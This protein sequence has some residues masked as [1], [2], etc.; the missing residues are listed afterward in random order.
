M[1]KTYLFILDDNGKRK[2]TFLKG[3]HGKDLEAL[4]AKADAEYPGDTQ[5]VGEGEEYFNQFAQGKIYIHGE[6]VDEPPYVPSPEEVLAAAKT[7]KLSALRQ[8]L[9]ATDY[10][11]IK[12][13]E[14]AMTAAEFEPVRLQRQAWR[15]AYNTIEAADNIAAVNAVTWEE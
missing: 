3:I 6:F 15:E 8:L 10:K 1:E 7:E 13:A 9:T 4:Q 5:L 14:G 11:A 12:F 2:A